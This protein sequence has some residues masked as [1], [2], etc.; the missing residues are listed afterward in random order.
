MKTTLFD[1]LHAINVVG[2]DRVITVNGCDPIEV[3]PPIKFN[4][5]GLNQY[6]IALGAIVEV[7]YLDGHH[8]DTFVN[9]PCKDTNI[10]AWLLL[11]SLAG[12]CD[13]YK[14]DRWFRGDDSKMI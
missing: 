2:V 7:K 6:Q 14:Y 1:L 13:G 10:E 5:F 11:S 9:D 12:I 4:P 3:C 8:F